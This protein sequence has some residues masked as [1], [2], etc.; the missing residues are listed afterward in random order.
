MQNIAAGFL[1]R[2]VLEIVTFVVRTVFIYKLSESF[3][4]ATSL[5][6]NILKVLN[7]AELG[8]GAS[9]SVALYKPLEEKNEDQIRALMH[10][11][12]KLYRMIGLSIAIIGIV[13]SAFIPYIVKEKI[14]GLDL[15]VVFFLYLLNTVVSYWFGSYKGTLLTADQKDYKVSL[16]STC[17][18]VLIAIGQLVVLCVPVSS[19]TWSFY[20]YLFVGIIG[21]I[22]N[23]LFVAYIAG[24]EYPYIN[25][26]GVVPIEPKIK[27]KVINNTKALSVARISSAAMTPIDSIIISATLGNGLSINGKYSNYT[28]IIA[29]ITSIFAMVSR[30]ITATIGNYIVKENMQKTEHLFNCIAVVFTWIYGFCFV[31]LFCLMNPFIEDIWLSER[32]L[33]P[34]RVVFL[35]SINFLIN[36]MNFAPVKFFQAAGLYWEVRYRY[37]IS[38]VINIFLSYLFGVVFQWGLEGVIFATTL[39]LAFTVCIDPY[40]VYKHL[41]CKRSTAYYIQY[42]IL[43]FVIVVTG[44]LTNSVCCQVKGI[45]DICA[46]LLKMLSCLILPNAIWYLLFHKTKKF[47]DAKQLVLQWT[48]NIIG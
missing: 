19:K 16:W 41:F 40:V 48:R 15:R 31:A 35:L 27:T 42:V 10:L 20:C 44:F 45:P 30:A 32:W 12:K 37:V 28:L 9:I 33:L 46:F 22:A 34:N 2:I 5:F 6:S 8:I 7:I 18:N 38:A 13:L 11:Y 47:E 26:K 4:G 43:L 39:A 25:K 3:L 36:G 17:F 29:G 23:N 14:E 21:N 1:D 24:R